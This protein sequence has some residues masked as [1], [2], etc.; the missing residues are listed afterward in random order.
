MPVRAR[1]RAQGAGR[2]AVGHPAQGRGGTRRRGGRRRQGHAGGNVVRRPGGV[3]RVAGNAR[4]DGQV[5]VREAPVDIARRIRIA[6]CGMQIARESAAGVGAHIGIADGSLIGRAGEAVD[7]AAHSAVEIRLAG[8]DAGLQRG[9]HRGVDRRRTH[10]GL[11]IGVLGGHVGRQAPRQ[12]ACGLVQPH[13][14]RIHRQTAQIRAAVIAEAGHVDEERRERVLRNGALDPDQIRARRPG[15]HRHL[16]AGQV[17]RPRQERGDARLGLD[18]AVVV[19]RIDAIGG[20][21]DH[22]KAGA[23]G[24][25]VAAHRTRDDGVRV[26]GAQ[27]RHIEG[28]AAIAGPHPAQETHPRIGRHHAALLEHHAADVRRAGA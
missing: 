16:R 3:R 1:Q 12:T 15:E 21:L 10:R 8:A 26:A 19:H 9:G 5:Q 11:Q 28:L 14:E 27:R 4:V 20:R 13:A 2:H 22:R 18:E 17:Q 25:G 24:S 6:A 23:R 7:G